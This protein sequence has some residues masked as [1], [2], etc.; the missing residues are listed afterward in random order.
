MRSLPLLKNRFPLCRVLLEPEHI[1]TA[2][3][4]FG[5]LEAVTQPARPQQTPKK[6]TVLSAARMFRCSSVLSESA[7][8]SS[9]DA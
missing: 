8:S 9:A 3:Y 1:T 4:T 2:Y 7:L 6:K 5:V